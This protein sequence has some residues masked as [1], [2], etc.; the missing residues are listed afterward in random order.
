MTNDPFEAKAEYDSENPSQKRKK[1][2]KMSV[3]VAQ[4]EGRNILKALGVPEAI[5]VKTLS[6][7]L[8]IFEGVDNIITLDLSYII[9]PE[10]AK[11]I[12]QVVEKFTLVRK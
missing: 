1:S 8:N 12:E 3:A 6:A 2:S 11:A 10:D 5:L 7:K 9:T 4:I